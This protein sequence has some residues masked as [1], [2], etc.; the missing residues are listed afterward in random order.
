MS[1]QSTSPSNWK[2]PDG[3]EEHIE[4]GLIS[5]TIGAA[6]GGAVGLIFFRSGKGMRAASIATGVGVALGSTVQRARYEMKK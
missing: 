2:L 4:R 3:I 6:V 1:D 5:T